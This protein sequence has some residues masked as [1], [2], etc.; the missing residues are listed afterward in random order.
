M[1]VFIFFFKFLKEIFF[2][3]KEEADFRS[4]Q[5]K[6]MRWVAFI[7]TVTAFTFSIHLGVRVYFL[8]KHQYE[9]QQKYDRCVKNSSPRVS[10]DETPSKEIK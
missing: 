3:K 10:S 4:S 9:L 8:A 1:N 7:L 5:F 6:P 2:D